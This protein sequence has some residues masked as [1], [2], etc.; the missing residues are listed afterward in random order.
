MLSEQERVVGM[1]NVVISVAATILAGI[2]GVYVG[3]ALNL[4][5]YLGIIFSIAAMGGCIIHTI[6]KKSAD[7]AN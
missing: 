4:E 7:T 5:G 6:E 3:V 1:K 2:I